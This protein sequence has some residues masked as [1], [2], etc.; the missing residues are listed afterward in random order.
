LFQAVLTRR[1]DP[2]NQARVALLDRLEADAARSRLS[3]E[4]IL[5]ALLTPCAHA[6]A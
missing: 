6:G 1:L 4:Q 3:C 2:M 5:T